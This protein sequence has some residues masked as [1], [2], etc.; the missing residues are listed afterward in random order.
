M[1]TADA[2]R[3]RLAVP[4]RGTLNYAAGNMLA[5]SSTCSHRAR[6]MSARVV[7]V[8]GGREGDRAHR[9]AS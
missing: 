3:Q 9:V 2:V 1:G 4:L 8:Q 7:K 6:Q 5:R